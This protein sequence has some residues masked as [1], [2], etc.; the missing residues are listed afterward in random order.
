MNNLFEITK[1]TDKNDINRNDG[2][3]PLRIGRRCKLHIYGVDNVMLIEYVPRENEDYS[4]VL[5]T[6]LVESLDESNGD[7]KVTT[8]NSIYYFKELN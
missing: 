3:Y 1:I 6:S 2:R 7:Y 8:M 5:R 4:G